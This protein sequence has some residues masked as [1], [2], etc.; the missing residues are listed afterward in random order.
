MVFVED[1]YYF[2]PPVEDIAPTGEQ[3]NVVQ[4]EEGEVVVEEDGNKVPVIPDPPKGPVFEDIHEPAPEPPLETPGELQEDPRTRTNAFP[5]PPITK[6]DEFL[7]AVSYQRTTPRTPPPVDYARRITLV[8]LQHN[9][10]VLD[11]HVNFVNLNDVTITKPPKKSTILVEVEELKIEPKVREA[12]KPEI[13]KVTK[14]ISRQKSALA[15]IEST[16]ATSP[17]TRIEQL[18]ADSSLAD[19]Y[20]QQNERKYFVPKTKAKHYRTQLAAVYYKNMPVRDTGL[21][22]GLPS[23][24]YL[25]HEKPTNYTRPTSQLSPLRY[26]S[27]RGQR[28]ALLP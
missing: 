6:A 7:R 11:Q 8:S 21:T 27:Y 13:K 19:I 23:Y 14:Q 10:I 18:L 22:A 4:T 5:D 25:G 20:K 26:T 3:P 2:S 12:L 24:G 17:Q 9:Q 15:A 16:R 28:V 1:D